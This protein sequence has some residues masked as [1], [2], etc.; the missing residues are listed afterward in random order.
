MNYNI[1]H[2][3]VTTLLLNHVRYFNSIFSYIVAVKSCTFA[4]GSMYR[5]RRVHDGM[6]DLHI[7]LSNQCLPASTLRVWLSPV[8]RY[9]SNNIYLIYFCHWL[10]TDRSFSFC[11]QVPSV[12]ITDSYDIAKDTIEVTYM[13]W[14]L[15]HSYKHTIVN[16]TIPVHTSD[17]N[18]IWALPD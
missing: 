13:I 17:S 18:S 2:L 10:S 5:D 7:C 11:T 16:T 8:V 9:A 1:L 14:Q 4:V 3:Q 12:N 6:F 15:R